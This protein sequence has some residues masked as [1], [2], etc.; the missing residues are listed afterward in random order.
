MMRIEVPGRR[1]KARTRITLA[2]SALVLAA[3][4]TTVTAIVVAMG[5]IPQ[6]QF[7]A[8]SPVATGT[9]TESPF[10]V[11][12]AT[13]VPVEG[14]VV[15]E[16]TDVVRL[17][18][19]F[20]V[21]A[22]IVIGAA[23]VWGSWLVAG[24][25]LR[26]LAGLN[27]AARQAA[28]GTFSHR[29]G[30]GAADDEF[31]ELGETFDHMLDRL[32]RS[33]DANERFAANVSHELRTP[34]ATTKVLIA[35]ARD[36]AE[37]AETGVLLDHLAAMN[38][39][40]VAI[41]DAMLDLADASS[42]PLVLADQDVAEI[43]DAALGEVSVMA[44]ARD[45]EIVV[46]IVDVSVRADKVLLE[47]VVANLLR[48]AVQHN[49]EHGTVW[50]RA[51]RSVS[52]VAMSVENTGAVVSEAV[53]AS[54]AEPFYRAE[55]RLAPRTSVGADSHGLGLTLVSRIVD[56]HSGT[57]DIRTRSG[58]GLVVEVTIPG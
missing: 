51:V 50:L 22:L 6:Y 56:A 58:G 14:V 27:A 28:A 10:P 8:A 12:V 42:T 30:L 1:L 44:A 37:H 7:T 24:R 54:L 46:D 20:G 23:G 17:L 36:G 11:T 2:A 21:I 13:A 32:E 49:Q 34:L 53:A 48:N 35:A 55:G 33:F 5:L 40:S 41:V 15:S 57:L 4:A 43:V 16:P 25:V 3:T 45:V 47:R 39:R 29:V 52:G 9:L 26:P 38:D 18:L 19:V 31:R